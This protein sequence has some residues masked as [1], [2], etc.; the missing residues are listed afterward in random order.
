MSSGSADTA[1]MTGRLQ[2]EAH[3]EVTFDHRELRI[4][5]RIVDAAVADTPER[6]RQGMAGRVDVEFM[7]FVMPDCCTY[8]FVM[9]HVD[10]D[11]GIAVFDAQGRIS[12][13]GFMEA[14]SG[15]FRA[16]QPYKYALEFALN[17]TDFTVFGDLADGISLDV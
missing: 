7:L 11:L 15:Y 4:G 3:Q 8:A 16:K 12:D 9:E 2:A 5:S 17:P 10:R 14:R 1:G 13:V 6:W